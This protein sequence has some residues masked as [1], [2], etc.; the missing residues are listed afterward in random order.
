MEFFYSLIIRAA[1]TGL[2]TGIIIAIPMG[3][4]GLESVRWTMSKGFK[5]G[6][7]V[8]SGSLIADA[9][10]VLLINFGL[11]DLIGSNKVLEVVLWMFSG[12]VIF[13]V[14]LRAIKSG[15]ISNRENEDEVIDKKEVKSRPVLTGFTVNF[16]NPMT[17]FFWL[18]LSGTVINVWREAGK[19]PYFLFVIFMLTGMFTSLFI[20]N[21][22]ASK[23]KK[24]STTKLS[25]RLAHLLAY[26]IT[27]IGV[28]FFAYGIYILYLLVR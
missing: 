23:G 14:G 18:T 5:Y 1:Y 6:L 11:L 27:A 28:V 2:V 25:G 3:P 7:M 17:H 13:I 16:F 4:A 15:Q 9:V 12:V 21:Y 10:D 19:L 22:L 8:A 20:I 24:V 26:G